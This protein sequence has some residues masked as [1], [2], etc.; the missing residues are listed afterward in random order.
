MNVQRE[1]IEDVSVDA[2]EILQVLKGNFYIICS[3]NN[4]TMLLS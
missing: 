2:E 4:T 1:C 3:L